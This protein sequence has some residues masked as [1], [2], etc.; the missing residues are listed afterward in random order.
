VQIDGSRREKRRGV[1]R[2]LRHVEAV[3]WDAV[4][5]SVDADAYLS[6]SDSMLTSIWLPL[7]FDIEDGNLGHAVTGEEEAETRAL[8]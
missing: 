3:A 2:K 6:I 1:R 8:P 7:Y 4:A 5:A